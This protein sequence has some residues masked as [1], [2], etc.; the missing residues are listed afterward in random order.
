MVSILGINFSNMTEDQVY[1]ACMS[2]IRA[3]GSHVV[4]TAGPEFVMQLQR[5]PQLRSLAQQADLVTADGVGIVIASKW[6]GQALP[7]RVTGVELALRLIGHAAAENLRVFLLGASNT[8]LERAIGNL[9][10]QYP[11]L[12]LA[13]QHGYFT[14]DEE[15]GIVE[16]I[17]QFA[18]HVLLV[19]LG[20]PRQDVF[21]ATH[22]QNL[23]VPLAM[24]IGGTLDVISGLVKRAPIAFRKIHLE[25]LYRLLKEPRRFKRQL[26]LPQFALKAWLEARRLGGA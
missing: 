22:R 7:E 1:E 24:G 23:N 13:G 12:Q 2:F 6:Y 26:S 16:Q 19:G 9:R 10:D 25:W 8:S 4:L 15:S 11:S 18:P 21:I 5:Q 20:Q 17:R 3:E 14:A